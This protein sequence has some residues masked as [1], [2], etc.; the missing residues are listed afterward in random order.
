LSQTYSPAGL[1]AASID[2]G[3]NTVRLRVVRR[4]AGGDWERLADEGLFCRLGEGVE[5]TG[6]IAE[7][8]F[9][10]A[11]EVTTRYVA[12][13]HDLDAE[14]I[15][16]FATAAVREA[17]NGPELLDA[18]ERAAGV[19]PR[20][21]SGEEEARLTFLGATHDTPDDVALVTDIGGGSTELA[22]GRAGDCAGRLSC[23]IGS[24]KLRAH[25]GLAEGSISPAA[26]E[27]GV[28]LAW[29]ALAPDAGR[30]PRMVAPELT[31]VGGTVTALAALSLGLSSYD[32]FRV[33]RHRMTLEGVGR[34][35]ERLAALST[36]ARAEL[37]CIA[38]DRA[39]VIVPGAMIL[40][41]LMRG[42]QTEVVRADINGARLGAILDGLARA[43][44]GPHFART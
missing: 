9:A 5:R 43:G 12:R 14:W 28:A 13:A 1:C 7:P 23:A 6:R 20:P 38:Q 37:P 10:R 19:R 33:Q 26:V 41:A 42:L 24:R 15:F 22:W 8:N 27:E 25:L 35:L 36:K 11:V 32:P 3:S 2:I 39:A 18:M 16:P 21:I 34:L 31:G 44:L 30:V 17:A 29:E 40:L 4:S